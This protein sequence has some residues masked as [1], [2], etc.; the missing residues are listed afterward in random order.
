MKFNFNKQ[1][2]I[3]ARKRMKEDERRD[4]TTEAE[5]MSIL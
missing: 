3:F 5:G 2:K 1:A 4:F